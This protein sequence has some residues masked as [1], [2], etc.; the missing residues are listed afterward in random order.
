MN[1]KLKSNFVKFSTIV[2]LG[3][4]PIVSRVILYYFNFFRYCQPVS[5]VPLFLQSDIIFFGFLI[6]IGIFVERKGIYKNTESFAICFPVGLF[7]FYLIL[8]GMLFSEEYHKLNPSNSDFFIKI[9]II[10]ALVNIVLGFLFAF[11]ANRGNSSNQR[12]SA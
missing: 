5:H 4:I 3:L 10:F 6:N 11:I 2:G 7:I 8:I 12:R 1:K 9:G